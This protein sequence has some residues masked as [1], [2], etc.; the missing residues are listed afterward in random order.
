MDALLAGPARVA[1]MAL[2]AAV[3]LSAFAGGAALVLGSASGWAPDGL[4]MPRG[5]LAGSGFTSYLVPGLVLAVVVG[6]THVAAAVATL[7]RSRWAVLLGA[8]AAFGLL[9]WIFVQMAVIPYSPLQA[10][11]EGAAIAGLALVLV[12]VGI[13]DVLRRRRAGT[14]AQH[15]TAA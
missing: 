4:A 12:E 5:Y 6:G 10:V 9:I 14:K 2:Q 11:Y 15:R 8:V 7:V 13:L 1:R 3:G